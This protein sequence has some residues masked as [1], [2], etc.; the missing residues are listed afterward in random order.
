MITEA[1]I[2]LPQSVIGGLRPL[3]GDSLSEP[4]GGPTD[5]G[6]TA[7]L[8]TVPLKVAIPRVPRGLKSLVR[9]SGRMLRVERLPSLGMEQGYQISR[10]DVVL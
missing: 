4:D 3:R 1:E 9:A 5:G 10:F 2:D 7:Q 8:G 6:P